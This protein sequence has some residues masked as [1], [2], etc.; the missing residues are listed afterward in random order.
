M[1][2]LVR[3]SVFIQLSE[4]FRKNEI[5]LQELLNR[6]NEFRMKSV[7]PQQIVQQSSPKQSLRKSILA[8]FPFMAKL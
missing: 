8:D 7:I 2:I 6:I 4:D 3:K 5:L 1:K